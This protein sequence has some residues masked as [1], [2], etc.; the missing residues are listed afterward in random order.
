MGGRYAT[1][2]TAP[3]SAAG[4]I[5]AGCTYARGAWA[6]TPLHAWPEAKKKGKGG[7][8]GGGKDTAGDPTKE[9]AA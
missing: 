2:G 4:L 8:K 7:D 3:Q 9:A 5:A 1:R 6:S